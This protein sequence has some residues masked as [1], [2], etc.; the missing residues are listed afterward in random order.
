MLI[1]VN[2]FLYMTHVM[3]LVMCMSMFDENLKGQV[4][5]APSFHSV[6]TEIFHFSHKIFIQGIIVEYLL[7]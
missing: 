1:F 6:E 5:D 7:L 2:D 3:L 4:H